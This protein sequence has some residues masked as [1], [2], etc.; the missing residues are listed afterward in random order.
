MDQGDCSEFVT[1]WAYA[2]LGTVVRPQWGENGD[3]WCPP[4]RWGSFGE[5]R[6]Q[7]ART[8]AHGAHIGRGSFIRDGYPSRAW[9]QG[10]GADQRWQKMGQ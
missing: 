7:R 9:K 5:E 3:P 1:R 8:E 2:A 4:W 10:K 6:E